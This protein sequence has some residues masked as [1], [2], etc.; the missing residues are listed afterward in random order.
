MVGT[1]VD[2][3]APGL[4]VTSDGKPKVLDVVEASGSGD[5]DTTTVRRV[6]PSEHT[7]VGLSGSFTAV[8]S[9]GMVVVDG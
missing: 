9:W 1:L 7:I 4:Q 8:V 3:G 2:P 6:A 5:V